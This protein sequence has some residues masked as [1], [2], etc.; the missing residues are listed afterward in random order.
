MNQYEGVF[1]VKPDLSKDSM[2]KVLSQ[3]KEIIAKHKGSVE[4]IDEWGKKRLAYPIQKFKE[5][6][7]YLIN[8]NIDPEAVDKMRKSFGLNESVLRV[9]ITRKA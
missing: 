4:R 9:L 7:Y 6:F 2:D 5:A 1:L 3:I 8:L